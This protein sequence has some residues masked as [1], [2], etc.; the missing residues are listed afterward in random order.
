MNILLEIQRL[1]HPI[2]LLVDGAVLSLSG[3][4]SFD[5]SACDVGQTASVFPQHFPVDESNVSDRTVS[6]VFYDTQPLVVCQIFCMLCV[7]IAVS[8]ISLE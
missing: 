2:K 6:C 7:H 5:T 4:L 1:I 8:C 3:Y